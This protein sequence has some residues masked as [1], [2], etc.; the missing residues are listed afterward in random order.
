MTPS[1]STVRGSGR[2]APTGAHD[3]GGAVASLEAVRAAVAS[4]P[5]PELPVVTVGALGMIHDVRVDGGD[6]VVELLPTFSGCPATEVIASDVRG[7]LSSIAGVETVDV[8]FLYDPPWTPA[9][10]SA[11]GREALRSF[12]ITP[13]GD[14]DAPLLQLLP[15]RGASARACPYC[16][17]TETDRES[18]FGPTPCRAIHFCRSCRQPFEAFKE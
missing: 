2:G 9:R 12:G 16:G 14:R 15:F 7:A 4:V 3:V 8:R 18:A 5:D 1:T 10:I 11:A 13:P 6:V 17:S